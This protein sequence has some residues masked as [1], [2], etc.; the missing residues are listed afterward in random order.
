MDKQEFLNRLREGLA[1]L[2]QEDIEERLGFYSEMI[3]DRMEEGLTEEQAVA[4]IESPEAIAALIVEETPLPRLVRERVRPKRALRAWE[5]VLLILGSPIWL[6]LG[7]AALAVLLSVY[8]VIWAVIVSL[9]AVDL[10]FAVIGVWLLAAGVLAFL[11]LQTGNAEGLAMIGAA[12]VLAGLAILLF[13]GC[14]AATCGAA[15][16]TARIGRW[17][18]S[19]LIRREN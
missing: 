4:E 11:P 5:L 15:R 1:G 18:K 14:R 7:I 9:W 10:A 2:P 12:L 17:I 16:L 8:I 3:D 13:F 6:A 19:L